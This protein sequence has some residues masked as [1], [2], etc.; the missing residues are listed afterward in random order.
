MNVTAFMHIT[1]LIL[2]PIKLISLTDSCNVE[3]FIC[4]L[5]EEPLSSFFMRKFGPIYPSPCIPILK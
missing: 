5:M 2:L 1:Y 4:S 3:F